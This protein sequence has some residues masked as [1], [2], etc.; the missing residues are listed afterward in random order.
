MLM[1]L[2]NIVFSEAGAQT[3]STVNT[4]LPEPTPGISGYG[5]DYPQEYADQSGDLS[6]RIGQYGTAKA[7]GSLIELGKRWDM[8]YPNGPK[9]FVGDLSLEGGADTPFHAGHESGTI[10]DIRPVHKSGADVPLDFNS[11]TYDRE[12]TQELVNEIL[13]D[14]NAEFILFNDEEIENVTWWDDHDDHLHVQYK[15]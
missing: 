4:Q 13:K 6:Y 5:R 10:V 2:I 7:V 14:P 1:G 15:E 9:I 8:K 3:N 11:S 12:K